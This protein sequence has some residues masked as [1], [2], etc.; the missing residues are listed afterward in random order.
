MSAAPVPG[1]APAAGTLAARAAVAW[2]AAAVVALGV[3]AG[4]VRAAVPAAA[5]T[6]GATP[7]SA[8]FR[9]RA[10]VSPPDRTPLPPADTV[11]GR[12]PL[13]NRS[14]LPWAG[15]VF[16][17]VLLIEP[18]EGFERTVRA[19]TPSDP[20]GFDR[21]FVDA[22]KVAGHP[23][24]DAGV[25]LVAWGGGKLAGS[26]RL[27]RAGLDAVETLVAAD[28]V[29]AGGK[30]L[31]GRRRPEVTDDPDQFRPIS[32]HESSQ[33]Y[34]SGHATGAFALAAVA[35]GDFPEQRWLPWV[36]WPAA[37]AVAASRVVGR[38]HWVTD[39]AA[40]AAL[41]ILSA[42]VVLRFNAG[43]RN[44]ARSADGIA[45]AA[46]SGDP[47]RR[48]PSLVLLPVPGGAGASLDI[49]LP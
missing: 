39:V 10:T 27:E 45:G 33:S 30:V 20:T 38:K 8:P 47:L 40:G 48:A 18:L 3:G 35:V 13:F 24:V 7:A 37:G 46:G 1:R 41:G 26:T 9:S 28:V 42:R 31:L 29:L 34:P 43:R 4:P 14:D 25:A 17:G 6:A 32:F 21:A 16:G 23:L 49:P 44:A 5:P 19:H 2:A 36:A 11:S 12:P 15:V 22:G